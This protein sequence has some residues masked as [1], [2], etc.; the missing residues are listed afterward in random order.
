MTQS[1]RGLPWAWIMFG[2][3]SL[4][5]LVLA[6]VL[7]SDRTK[8]SWA[9]GGNVVML[10]FAISGL[11][12]ILQGIGIALVLQGKT[13]LGGTIQMAASAVHVVKLDGVIG[14][15]GGLL[16]RRSG[17]AILQPAAE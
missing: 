12:L 5:F 9:S 16:A 2:I 8:E 6:E 1:P 11:T 7:F 10:L 13:R 14:L 3:M 4:E 17:E 15:Y